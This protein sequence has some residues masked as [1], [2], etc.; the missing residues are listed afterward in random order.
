MAR[1]FKPS[2]LLFRSAAGA[3]AIA[4]YLGIASAIA[5]L[6]WHYDQEALHAGA[7]AVVAANPR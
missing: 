3:A 7:P 6:A 1:R 2:S 5:A 4:A